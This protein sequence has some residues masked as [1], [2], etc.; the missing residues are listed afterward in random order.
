MLKFESNEE[1]GA[2]KLGDLPLDHVNWYKIHR[3]PFTIT[4]ELSLEIERADVLEKIPHAE[5]P[6]EDNKS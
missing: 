5:A 4:L 2:L 1:T 6:I 3:T